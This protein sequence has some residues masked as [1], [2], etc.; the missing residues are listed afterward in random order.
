ME[1]VFSRYYYPIEYYN[2]HVHLNYNFDNSGLNEAEL[3]ALLHEEYKNKCEKIKEVKN[4][5]Y[6]NKYNKSAQ[7]FEEEQRM[8][9]R[10]EELKRKKLQNEQLLKKQNYNKS[11]YNKNMKNYLK[12]K[13]LKEKEKEKAKT[14]NKLKKSKS[15][16]KQEKKTNKLKSQNLDT[17]SNEYI[18]FDK[19][20]QKEINEGF[21]DNLEK[22]KNLDKSKNENINLKD[23]DTYIDN[24]VVDLRYELENQLLEEIKNKNR[25]INNSE[26]KDEVNDKLNTIKKFRNFGCLPGHSPENIEKI[27]NKES[28]NKKFSSEFERRRFIKSMKNAINERLGQQNIEIQNICNCGNLYKKLDTLI[29]NG[30]LN[31]TEID[32]ENNCIFYKNQKEYLQKL[33][34]VLESVKELASNNKIKK[35]K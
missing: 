4:K 11:V 25:T 23:K 21:V 12:E 3:K 29:E 18:I 30:N 22:K 13:E 7:L 17:N 2:P 15:L 24:N 8:K 1:K 33:N 26:L 27:K 20:I 34:E 16:N 10:E 28:K 35:D 14:I 5:E 19:N 6:V 32:C 31:I 9:N